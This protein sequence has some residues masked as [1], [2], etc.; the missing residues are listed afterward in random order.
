MD[1]KRRRI[2][3]GAGDDEVIVVEDAPT[4]DIQSPELGTSGMTVP[5]GLG[6]VVCRLL[7]REGHS[8]VVARTDRYSELLQRHLR[9]SGRHRL[10]YSRHRAY[11]QEAR[12][13]REQTE[14]S[15]SEQATHATDYK[16]SREQLFEI[17]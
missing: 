17:D 10:D 13:H 11:S 12:T 1:A 7:V 9:P 2:E 4:G 15:T 3:C 16:P 6:V 5:M 14:R 8:P